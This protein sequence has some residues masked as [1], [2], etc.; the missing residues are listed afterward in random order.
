MIKIEPTNSRL[1][2]NSKMAHTSK[3]RSSAMEFYPESS[4]I[5]GASQMIKRPGTNMGHIN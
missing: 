2:R 1:G 5:I 3:R 4:I